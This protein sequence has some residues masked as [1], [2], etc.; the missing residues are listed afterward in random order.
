MVEAVP[1]NQAFVTKL[2]KEEEEPQ[3]AAPQTPHSVLLVA[4]AND[5]E[6]FVA[7]L[8][9]KKSIDG[10]LSLSCLL[11]T[12]RCFDYISWPQHPGYHTWNPNSTSMGTRPNE[13]DEN[14]PSTSSYVKSVRDRGRMRLTTN[15]NHDSFIKNFQNVLSFEFQTNWH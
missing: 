1:K 4:A 6:L 5:D 12:P 3:Q 9:F 8:L 2:T 10:G 7:S 11:G 15:H 14:T 13:R